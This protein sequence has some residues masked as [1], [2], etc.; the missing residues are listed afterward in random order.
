MKTKF[1]LFASFIVIF[2]S[3]ANAQD[4]LIGEWRIVS[5]TNEKGNVPLDLA[6]NTVTF[7]KDKFYGKICNRFG[8]GYTIKGDMLEIPTTL[9]TLIGCPK[10]KT[11]G[12]VD[13]V[14]SKRTYFSF[15]NNVLIL[16]DKNKNITLRLER[17]VDAEPNLAGKWQL[18]TFM[19][20]GNVF[21]SWTIEEDVFLNIEKDKMSGN[22]GCNS[23]KG[24]VAIKQNTVK[25]SKITSTEKFC[26]GSIEKQYFKALG[27]ITNFTFDF[28]NNRVTMIDESGK[29]ALTFYRVSK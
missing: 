1:I 25:F 11:D 19:L 2:T 6:E 15:E 7:E 9:S 13:T 21:F 29:N 10:I 20:K 14:F 22:G 23:Y 28:K 16:T 17:F 4:S 18:H 3:F 5:I 8:G 12:L 24:N 27:K 26:K